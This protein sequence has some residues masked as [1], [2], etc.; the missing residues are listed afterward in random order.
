MIIEIKGLEKK[1]NKNTIALKKYRFKHWQWD[2]WFTREKWFRKNH[3]N[4]NNNNFD[5]TNKR[6]S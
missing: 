2:F 3:F 6:T 5:G 4:E 1:F